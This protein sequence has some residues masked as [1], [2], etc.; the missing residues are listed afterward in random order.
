[1]CQYLQLWQLAGCDNCCI[2]VASAGCGAHDP[3]LAFFLGEPRV[4][5]AGQ[6]ILKVSRVSI[7]RNRAVSPSASDVLYMLKLL[8]EER[9]TDDRPDVH[10]RYAQR[11]I[12]RLRVSFLNSTQ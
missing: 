6:A 7:K 10:S 5:L 3:I 9:P 8:S 11:Q 4:S 2:N 1:M 12:K